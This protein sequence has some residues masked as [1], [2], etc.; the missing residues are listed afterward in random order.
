MRF[1]SEEK[2]LLAWRKRLKAWDQ[3]NS[4]DDLAVNELI[5]NAKMLV[6]YYFR[7]SPV[8][9]HIVIRRELA[10]LAKGLE[11]A[12]EALRDLG[13]DGLLWVHAAILPLSL[14]R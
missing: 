10:Q 8:K 6:G 12:S 9:S 14:R 5:A 1:P 11:R 2:K 3:P 13:P 4:I 7:S